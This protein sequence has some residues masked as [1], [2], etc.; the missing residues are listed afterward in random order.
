MFTTILL[1]SIVYIFLR[2]KSHANPSQKQNTHG[3]TP[4]MILYP[5]IYTVCT[6][7]IASLRIYALAGHTVSLSYFCM[8]GTMIACNG[9]LD[10]L[11]YASTRA[12]IVFADFPPSEDA[13]IDTFAWMGKGA[14]NP[15]NNSQSLPTHNHSRNEVPSRN[16]NYSRNGSRTVL[17]R[18]SQDTES[19][20]QTFGMNQI[21]VKG[22]VT[23]SVASLEDGSAGRGTLGNETTASSSAHTSANVSATWDLRSVAS[24]KSLVG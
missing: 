23:V 8:G 4:L 16:T 3:A 22:E 21:G 1:Y 13:G 2:H 18:R 9:W 17:N 24:V 20:E 15:L 19:L 10:V 7:P 5:L 11:L 6:A 12:D 14:A